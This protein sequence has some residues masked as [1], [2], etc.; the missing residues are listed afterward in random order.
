MSFLINCRVNGL[1]IFL[2]LFM[3]M[4]FQPV[5]YLIAGVADGRHADAASNGL[6]A[7]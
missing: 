7:C 1:G 4:S 5:L 3:N 2:L 6:A